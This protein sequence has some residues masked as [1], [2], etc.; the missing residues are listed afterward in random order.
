MLTFV[1]GFDQDEGHRRLTAIITQQH[2]VDDVIGV[3]RV[4]IEPS[5]LLV[6]VNRGVLGMTV[7]GEDMPGVEFLDSLDD[8]VDIFAGRVRIVIAPDE[9]HNVVEGSIT[10][11]DITSPVA[12]LPG[13]I[14]ESFVEPSFVGA[15]VAQINRREKYLNSFL[16]RLAKDPVGVFE[17]LFVGRGKIAGSQKRSL[18][19]AIDRAAEFVLDQVDDD[20]VES[21]FPAILEIRFRLFFRQT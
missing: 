5:L 10:L 8:G 21:L 11:A 20:G 1:D 15:D 19:V 3:G 9:P 12:A 17:I 4:E 13:T 14:G 18:T 7:G 6:L 16:R 2:P